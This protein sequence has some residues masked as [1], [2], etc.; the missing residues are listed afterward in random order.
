MK[1]I[2]LI[3]LL[4]GIS[5][6]GAQPLYFTEKELLGVITRFH[7]VAR[8]ATIDIDR[9]SAGILAA[10]GGF[11]PLFNSEASRKVFGGTAY[12]D[13]RSA[14]VSIPTWYGIELYAGQERISGARLNPE[15]TT[16]SV[17]YLGISVQP[18]QNLLMDKRR[19]VLLQAKNM[20]L[21]SEVQQR[22]V[23]ND[24]LKEGLYAYW[25]WWQQYHILQI[26]ND[27]LQNSINRFE[28]VKAASL[29]G[30]R[31][32]IDTV[33][34][35]T[36]VQ[37]FEIKRSEAV[38]QL[39][40]ARLELTAF[41]W[42]GEGSPAVLPEN[43]MPGIQ[44]PATSFELQEILFLAESHPELAQYDYRLRNLQIEK[45]L[46]FQ[47][48]LPDLKI[49]YNQAGYDLRKTIDGPWFQNNY[50]FGINLSIPLR[51]SE[52][53]GNYQ[54]TKLGIERTLLDQKQKQ[55]EVL[56]K[57]RQYYQEN[58]QVLAQLNIQEQLL[59][60]ITVLQRGEE[61]KFRNGESSLFLLNA[62]EL[63]RIETEQKLQEL[64]AKAQKTGVALK[65]SAGLL[66]L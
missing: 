64:K 35:Y 8:Q 20:Q 66:G 51:L 3:F 38:L 19:A 27:A 58:Q 50:R 60:N 10:R 65:W 44:V 21:L 13:Y 31:P 41:L 34:A 6:A 33:E 2:F 4:A 30:E 46:T 63:K 5:K 16:G 62:R 42:T 17:M 36:Q 39:Y 52:A 28:L 61:I 55:L 43:V 32:A 59:V 57:V 1:K 22:M 14:E 40:R 29:L 54:R 48:L 26:V 15:K 18:L 49:R 47:A 25:D 37:F 45:R 53:R 24:L 9:A 12:Y 7:P 23:L 56:N 11:D